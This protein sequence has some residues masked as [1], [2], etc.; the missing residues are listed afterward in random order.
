MIVQMRYEH[1]QKRMMQRVRNIH[2]NRQKIIKYNLYQN[3]DEDGKYEIDRKHQLYYNC[4]VNYM[5]SSVN[6]PNVK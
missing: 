6:D 1:Y 4:S 2:N 3:V 5:K